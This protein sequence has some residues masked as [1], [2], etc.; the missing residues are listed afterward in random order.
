MYPFYKAGLQPIL[1]LRR[2]AVRRGCS[3]STR[4]RRAPRNSRRPS[5]LTLTKFSRLAC[6]SGLGLLKFIGSRREFRLKFFAVRFSRKFSILAS[7]P[8][9]DTIHPNLT[10]SWLVSGRLALERAGAV[11]WPSCG[12]FFRRSI[13][14]NTKGLSNFI[15]MMKHKVSYTLA[16]TTSWCHSLSSSSHTVRL[17][18]P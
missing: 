17:T 11:L 6:S 8:L 15:K 14:E 3:S 2:P 5:G 18:T 7:S 13:D 16:I 4:I 12:C 1:C 9:D 10:H